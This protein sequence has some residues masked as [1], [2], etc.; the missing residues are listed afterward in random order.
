[1]EWGRGDSVAAGNFRSRH[2]GRLGKNTHTHLHNGGGTGSLES[3]LHRPDPNKSH[4]PV[5]IR[6]DIKYVLTSV[7]KRMSQLRTNLNVSRY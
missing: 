1:M 7:Y 4:L 3:H 6:V 2:S 5:L